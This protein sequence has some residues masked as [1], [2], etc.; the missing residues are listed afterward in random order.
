MRLN[1]AR[2]DH[3]TP[4]VNHNVGSCAFAA[5]NGLNLSAADKQITVDD[6]IM[7]IHRYDDAAFDQY[8]FVH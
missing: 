2:K 1:K 4:R 3:V 5:V 8:R 7:I 6:G